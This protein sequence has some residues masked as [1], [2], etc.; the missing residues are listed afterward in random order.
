MYR[1]RAGAE[2]GATGPIKLMWS[3]GDGA[4]SRT[5]EAHTGAMGPDPVHM[6]L[7]PE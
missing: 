2:A 7:G 3:Q 5:C 1:A 6:G 4:Q